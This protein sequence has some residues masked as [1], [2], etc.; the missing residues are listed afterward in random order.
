MRRVKTLA[1]SMILIF[2][3]TWGAS[4]SSAASIEV[5]PGESI[6]AAIDAAIGGDEVI[7]YPGTY[8]ENLT[9]RGAA[10]TVRST[11]P[12]D[13]SVVDATIID[14]K[15]KDRVFL[16]DCGEGR[17]LVLSGLTMRNGKS[18]FGGGVACFNSSSPTIINCVVTANSADTYGGIGCRDSSPMILNCII[19]ENSSGSIGGGIGCS[20]A[21][22]PEIIHCTITK[23]SA[24]AAGGGLGCDAGASPVVTNCILWGDLAM[25]EIA[26]A[27]T[28]NPAITYSDVLGG[29]PGEGNINA[30]PLFVDPAEGDYHLQAASPCIDTGTNDETLEKRDKDGVPRP[31]DGDGDGV[32]TC[33]M[34]AYEFVKE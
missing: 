11:N 22:S 15:G 27:D 3:V 8:S 32:A 12:E 16:I 4:V 10:I 31:Q 18:N 26:I 33:D 14:G 23:N 21:S 2:A 30:D 1:L 9:C 24:A 20:N 29:Y 6:Q 17:D 13:S 5:R 25:R 19:M 34:G 28:G 7:I